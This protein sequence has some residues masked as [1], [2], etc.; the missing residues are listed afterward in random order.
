[1]EFRRTFSN[2]LYAMDFIIQIGCIE[3]VDSA[4]FSRLIVVMQIIPDG[5]MNTTGRRTAKVSLVKK[6]RN[7][8]GIPTNKQSLERTFRQTESVIVYILVPVFKTCKRRERNKNQNK[9]PSEIKC[10]D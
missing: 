4:T 9:C 5:C 2:A 6:A 8:I 10:V 3:C 7:L 1:M